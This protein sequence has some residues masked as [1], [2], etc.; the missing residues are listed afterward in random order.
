MGSGGP[1]VLVGAG[2]LQRAVLRFGGGAHQAMF[3]RV[4]EPVDLER[5]DELD[6]AEL[7]PEASAGERRAQFHSLERLVGGRG[8]RAVLSKAALIMLLR[9][10]GTTLG[11]APL[12]PSE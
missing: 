4:E 9:S 5:V 8:V 7:R 12:A 3:E 10:L 1:S 11:K 2:D 6:R